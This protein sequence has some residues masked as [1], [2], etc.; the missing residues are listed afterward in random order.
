[1]TKKKKSIFKKKG[2]V[3]KDLTR[4]IF[5]VLNEDNEKSYNHKQIA[6]KLKISDTDGKTQIIKKLAELATSKQIKEVDRGKFQVNVDKKYSIGTLDVTS[7]G[8]GYFV[9]DDYEDDIFIPNIN[10]GKGLHN[11]TVKAYVYKRRKST[12]KGKA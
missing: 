10:L 11:D 5:K 8:N 9:T 6:A 7:T 2:N 12:L 1:M 4:N 3:V